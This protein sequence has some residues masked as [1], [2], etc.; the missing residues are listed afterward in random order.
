M[1]ASQALADGHVGD[2]DREQGNRQGED[3]RVHKS[4]VVPPS[5]YDAARKREQLRAE[6]SVGSSYKNQTE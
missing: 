5:T 4:I 6:I 2:R 1:T 3:E